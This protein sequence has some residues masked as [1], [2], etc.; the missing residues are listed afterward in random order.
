MLEIDKHSN[1]P[2]YHS[3]VY[4]NWYVYRNKI[5]HM[6]LLYP[7]GTS[8]EGEVSLN[9]NSTIDFQTFEGKTRGQVHEQRS[10]M[11]LRP[12]QLIHLTRDNRLRLEGNRL[13]ET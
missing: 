3:A 7:G 9:Q 4:G 2:L 12:T 13:Q 10:A 5:F 11:V 8:H 1:S 6:S